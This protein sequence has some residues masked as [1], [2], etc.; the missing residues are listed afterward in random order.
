MTRRILTFAATAVAMG[1]LAV[2]PLVAQAASAPTFTSAGTAITASATS[3]VDV[4]GVATSVP[5][6]AFNPETGAT[7]DYTFN[8]AFNGTGYNVAFTSANAVAGAF[9]LLNGTATIPYTITGA[10]IDDTATYTSGAAGGTLND[11]SPDF[12]IVVPALLATQ[13]KTAPAGS[14]ADTLTFTVTAV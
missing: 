2:A 4:T 9:E 13:L 6:G 14:Y 3:S 8:V 12:K 10:S 11:A 7:A 5:L 1:S